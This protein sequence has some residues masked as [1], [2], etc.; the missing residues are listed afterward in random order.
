MSIGEI[1]NLYR[2][3]ELVI[4][5]A[6]QRLFRWT[7]YQKSRL[8]ESILL[9]IPI[10]SIF[11]SQREDGVWEVV[12]GLQRLSTILEFVGELSDENGKR[13]PPSVLVGTNY[14]PHLQDRT[15]DTGE[16]PLDTGQRIVFKRSKLDIK[17]V[18]EAA[19]RRPSTTSLIAST[20]ADPSSPIR[21]LGTH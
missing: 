16:E 4:R 7:P 19:E 21:N 3:R 10:P 9:G 18:K 6:F 2:D 14:L 13:R 5:P 20:Q 1:I 11:V 12:D 8:I 15:F 17:I